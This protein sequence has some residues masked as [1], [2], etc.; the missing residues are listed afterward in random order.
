[1]GSRSRL[2]PWARKKIDLKQ[3]REVKILLRKYQLHTVCESARCPNQGECFGRGLA[4]FMIMGD[5]C[6]RRCAFCSVR[7]G[8]PLPLD[9]H[10]P[11][12]VAEATRRME[13]NHV[14]VTS[15]TRDDL[16]DGGARH[17][18]ETVLALKRSENVKS[19]E[20][21]TSDFGG[22]EESLREVLLS[23]PDIFN[24]NLE[25]IPRLYSEI[26]PQAN[27][28]R[29]LQILRVAATFH[30]GIMTKSGLMVGFG[31]QPEEVEQVLIDL[32]KAGCSLVTIGQYLRPELKNIPVSEYV[33]EKIF[34]RYETFGKRLG[35]KA[36]FSS[37]FVR[38]SYQADIMAS[39]FKQ[40]HL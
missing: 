30:R 25:T 28:E 36:V 3:L 38:S 15:V 7:K 12:R 29:S 16:P 5:I 14:V 32:K 33:D 6:T 21:L 20:V 10:E 9:P 24:H 35:F 23:E 13:L 26:R 37:P 40:A 31:E 19:I 4:T 22:C 39:R 34:L 2:A 17:Y 8:N 11:L 18:S 1:M 27:Y